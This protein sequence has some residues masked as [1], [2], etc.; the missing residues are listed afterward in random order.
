[1]GS[2]VKKETLSLGKLLF[3]FMYF[4]KLGRDCKSI[5]MSVLN[6][7]CVS[8]ITDELEDGKKFF[9][10]EDAK[11]ELKMAEFITYCHAS[12]SNNQVMIYPNAFRG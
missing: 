12:V 4:S 2:G 10:K 1:M 11:G 8:P 6:S 9:C 5:S 7:S 3:H